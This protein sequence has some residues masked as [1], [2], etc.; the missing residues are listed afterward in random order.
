MIAAIIG[1]VLYS[2][3]HFLSTELALSPHQEQDL[4]VYILPEDLTVNNV[5]LRNEEI[6][7][8]NPYSPDSDAVC[9]LQHSGL[10]DVLSSSPPSPSD[11]LALRLVLRIHPGSS[12]LQGSERH[13]IRSKPGSSHITLS[14]LQFHIIKDLSSADGLDQLRKSPL[15]GPPRPGRTTAQT[16]TSSSSKMDVSVGATPSSSSMDAAMDVTGSHAPMNTSSSTSELTGETKA[17]AMSDDAA[18][19]ATFASITG[20][21]S[22]TTNPVATSSTVG[23]NAVAYGKR[24]KRGNRKHQEEI[25]HRISIDVLPDTILQFN[26]SNELSFQYNLNLICDRGIEPS[27]WTSHRLRHAVVMI[28]TLFDRYELSWEQDLHP[29][30]A[31]NAQFDTYRFALVKSPASKTRA[32]HATKKVPL[33]VQYA[34]PVHRALDWSQLVWGPATLTILGHTYQLRRIYW[35]SRSSDAA[36]ASDST[37]TSSNAASVPPVSNSEGPNGIH[38]I[39]VGK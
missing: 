15:Y 23:A 6:W 7:G 26:L 13:G 12:D 27:Q 29:H 37:S 1:P 39:S 24:H 20:S 17:A 19:G 21:S 14:A 33:D 2:P 28:E 22:D 36:A 11:M 18:S 25:D 4:H 34:V 32:W 3:D 16:A 10:Y 38:A 5:A 31:T 8:S 35:I 30:T 9:M